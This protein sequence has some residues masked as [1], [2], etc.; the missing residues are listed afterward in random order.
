MFY[1]YGIV[2]LGSKI[3]VAVSG[4]MIQF[5]LVYVLKISVENSIIKTGGIPI[6]LAIYPA[7]IFIVCFVTSS[8][9]DKM[10]K[11]QGRKKTMTYGFLVQIIV[12]ILFM[13]MSPS[14]S[15]LMYPTTILMGIS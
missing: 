4:T 14:L 9:M 7:I 8:Y 1:W 13:V 10:Y 6:E 3:L 2:Y 15:Y 5:Y 11:L 12:S